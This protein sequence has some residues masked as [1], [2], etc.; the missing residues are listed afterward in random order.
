MLPVEQMVPV[1]FGSVRVPLIGLLG[2]TKVMELVLPLPLKAIEP[3][4]LLEEPSVS[5][6]LF[7]K[8]ATTLALAS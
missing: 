4:T 1:S 2:A 3:V 6:P 5:K 7:A 8:L